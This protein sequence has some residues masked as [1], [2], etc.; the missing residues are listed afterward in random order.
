MNLIIS[1]LTQ[2]FRYF[3]IC[4]VNKGVHQIVSDNEPGG[5]IALLRYY[6]M[7]IFYFRGNSLDY[8]VKDQRINFVVM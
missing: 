5:L 6:V 3:I 8:P 1:L 2:F 7:S 4:Q